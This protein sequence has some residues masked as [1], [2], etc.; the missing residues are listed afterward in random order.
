MSERKAPHKYYPPDYDPAKI[1]RNKTKTNGVFSIR[2]MAPFNMKCNTCNEFIY[3]GKKFN[4]RKEDIKDKNYLGLTLMRFYIRC[5]KCFAEITFRTDLENLDYEIE[6]G[7]TRNFDARRTAMLKEK[8]NEKLKVEEETNAMKILENRTK[9]SLK[10]I[11]QIEQLEELRDL[12]HSTAQIDQETLLKINQEYEKNLER[13]KLEEED[14]LTK[15]ILAKKT[16]FKRLSDDEEPEDN[17]KVE[18]LQFVSK[19]NQ[20]AEKSKISMA[21]HRNA[22]SKISKMIKIKKKEPTAEIP[23]YNN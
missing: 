9:E 17:L 22:L 7:A 12:K 3:K 21:N 8:E 11:Q 2:T 5:P 14:R 13:M 16:K 19:S 4:S 20:S 10:E 1:P 18:S 23:T 15:E 6:G